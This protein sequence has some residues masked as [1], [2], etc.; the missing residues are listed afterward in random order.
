M[1]LGDAFILFFLIYHITH[2][3]LVGTHG[4]SYLFWLV[5]L[6]YVYV[7]SPKNVLCFLTRLRLEHVT[8]NSLYLQQED[9]AFFIFLIHKM[10]L[11]VSFFV[12]DELNPHYFSFLLSFI[13]KL[14]L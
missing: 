11:D 8:H 2:I 14:I 9:Y 3:A 1:R 6:F 10:L 13:V 12:K 4:P 7:A 5:L